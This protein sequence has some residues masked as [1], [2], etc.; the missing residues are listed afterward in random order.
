MKL[1][2]LY[3]IFLLHMQLQYIAGFRKLKVGIAAHP[4]AVLITK[5]QIIICV[6]QKIKN[7]TMKIE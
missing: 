4:V 3:L 7:V 5:S 2:I 1:P 6:I